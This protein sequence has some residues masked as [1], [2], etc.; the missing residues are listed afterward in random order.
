MV[1]VSGTV[2][3]RKKGVGGKEVG[4]QGAVHLRR[5]EGGLRELVGWAA[6]AWEKEGAALDGLEVRW[7]KGRSFTPTPTTPE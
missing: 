2:S 1:W 6:G 5:S 7:N 4:R 3:G